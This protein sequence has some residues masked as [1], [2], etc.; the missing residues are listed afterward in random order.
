MWDKKICSWYTRKVIERIF[1]NIVE[2]FLWSHSLCVKTKKTTISISS[3]NRD[4]DYCQNIWIE[5]CHNDC[6][7]LSR[8]FLFDKSLNL[9]Y[10]L[11][12]AEIGTCPKKVN[13]KRKVQLKFCPRNQ[14]DNRKYVSESTTS[15]AEIKKMYVKLVSSASFSF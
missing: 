11:R 7:H 1:C 4:W 9:I 13:T 3:I 8:Y 12:S 15:H 6:Q 2:L 10:L 5:N 14:F